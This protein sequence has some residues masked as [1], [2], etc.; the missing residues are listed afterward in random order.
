MSAIGSAAALRPLRRFLQPGGALAGA[1][2][3]AVAY[4]LGAQAAFYLGT[5]TDKIFAPFWPPNIILFCALLLVPE[6]RWWHFIAAAF[7][8]HV[9]CRAPGRNAVA[10]LM[11][12]F[13]TNCMVALLNA[14]AVRRLLGD[15][16]WFSNLRKTASL[17]PD[18][19]RREPRC[20]GA[21]RCV[22]SHPGRRGD[23]RTTGCSGPI[24][25]PAMP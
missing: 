8:A 11:V 19:G 15:P 3:V 21:G 6:R 10:T 13:V 24:G 7:P 1:I 20:F 5:L 17:Y 14:F 9:A 25:I 16:P 23:R 18:H 22:H 4:Y 12:A 2:A